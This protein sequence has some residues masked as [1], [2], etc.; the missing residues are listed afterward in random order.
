MKDF[1]KQPGAWIEGLPLKSERDQKQEQ[2]GSLLVS[3]TAGLCWRFTRTWRKELFEESE[4]IAEPFPRLEAL[5]ESAAELY[6]GVY[7]SEKELQV[8]QKKLLR[9]KDG[10][11]LHQGILFAQWFSGNPGRVVLLVGRGA[12]GASTARHAVVARW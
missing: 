5:A 9:D 7:P 12:A 10:L 1:A 6:P 8:E 3:E 11:E 4:R 2:A